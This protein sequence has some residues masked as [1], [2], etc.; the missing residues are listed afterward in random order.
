MDGTSSAAVPKIR[1]TQAWS[2]FVKA[3]VD[4]QVKDIDD[5]YRKERDLGTPFAETVHLWGAATGLVI[6]GLYSVW[7][8]RWKLIS[9]T[10]ITWFL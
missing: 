10:L 3:V 8:V 7:N 6:G 2:S 1:V 4:T 9:S 5:K